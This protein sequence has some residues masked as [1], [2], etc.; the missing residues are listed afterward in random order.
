MV[1]PAALLEELPVPGVLFFLKAPPSDAT[2]PAMTA[3][4][5]TPAAIISRACGVPKPVGNS[6]MPMDC[7]IATNAPPMAPIRP[8]SEARISGNA[9]IRPPC[10]PLLM[11]SAAALNGPCRPPKMSSSVLPRPEN[12]LTTS[13]KPPVRPSKIWVPRSHA[14]LASWLMPSPRKP[15]TCWIRFLPKSSISS[16]VS[17]ARPLYR[18][19]RTHCP[20]LSQS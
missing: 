14:P 5:A 7:S 17:G 18:V 12:W 20:T 3:A 1:L 2:M 15:L 19:E 6:A 11:A 16:L 10:R 13:P 8:P 9:E 4:R